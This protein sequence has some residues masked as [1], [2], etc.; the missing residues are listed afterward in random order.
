MIFFIHPDNKVLGMI[1]EDSS[2]SLILNFINRN[3]KF[4]F[5]KMNKKLNSLANRC[6]HR[7]SPNTF[8]LGNFQTRTQNICESNNELNYLSS[9]S[10]YKICSSIRASFSS[11]DIS[12]N[13]LYV[14][15]KSPSNVS[16][17]PFIFC[18]NSIRF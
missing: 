12:T 18:S 3:I 15:A 1:H 4:Y 2:A 16:S 13:D 14:P 8:I 17:D 6:S 10:L 5:K 9:A 7:R 11:L